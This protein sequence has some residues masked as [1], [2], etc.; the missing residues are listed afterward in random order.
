[1]G[2]SSGGFFASYL[3]SKTEKIFDGFFIFSPALREDNNELFSD[4]K[5]V[6]NNKQQN[7]KFIYLTVGSNEQ[8]WFQ[9]AYKNMSAFLNENAAD[10]INIHMSVTKNADHMQ[11]PEMSL[12]GA[13]KFAYNTKSAKLAMQ[14]VWVDVR[15]QG[16]YDKSHINGD[17]HI[18]HKKIVEQFTKL[19]PNKNT[20]VHLYCYSGGRAGKSKTALE[21][22]G[23][24]NV[25]NAGGIKDARKSRGLI[26]N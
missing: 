2:H 24:K 22:A 21:K 23:Y 6:L 7:P 5:Q 11:N 26:A 16:E 10:N 25:I 17:I 13:L 18:P 20:E 19:Y 3:M 9:S 4:L 8:K 14:T 12:E 15:S 1:M